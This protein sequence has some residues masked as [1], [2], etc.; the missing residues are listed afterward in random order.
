MKIIGICGSPRK[1]GNTSFLVK[2]AL[3]AAEEEG[4]KTEY[5]S[6]YDKE[7]N[8]CIAC[9][10]CKQEG[11]CVIMDD[12][13]E[14]LEK[15]EEADGIIIGSPV[16]F[17]GVSAQTKMLFDRSRPCRI[18][19]KLKNKVGGAIS[20][21]ASRNGG[22]ETTIRQIHDFMLIHSMIVVGDN[23]PTAHYG[24]TGV[25][26]APGACQEDEFGITT[27]RNLGKKVAE[28]VKL[29]KKE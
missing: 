23:E 20:V 18:G 3:K 6:L 2:E 5:V 25:G 10:V 11:K 8:P 17:G 29:I 13:N 27:A 4:V 21:G 7:L 15:M 28:V 16:Y 26:G 22:Q 14:I 1:N 24:G 12:I 19:F 9:D